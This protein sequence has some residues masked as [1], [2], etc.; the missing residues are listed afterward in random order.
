MVR[1]RASASAASRDARSGSPAW[2]A[3]LAS[4]V[5]ARAWTSGSVM[6]RARASARSG[7]P[8]WAAALA[9]SASACAW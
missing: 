8:A 2:A 6:V 4:P 7:S 5:S 1:A 3:A 9:S